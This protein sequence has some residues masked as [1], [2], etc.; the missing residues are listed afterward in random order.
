MTKLVDV[1]KAAGVS[2]G[3]ASN[4]FNRPELVRT[5][6]RARVE[7]VAREL[8]YS[9]PNP[10]GRLLRSGKAHAIGVIPPGAFG[11]SMM[12]HDPWMR[13]F[14]A[15]VSDVCE[16]WGAGL[17]MVSGRDDQKTSGIRNALVDGF[18]LF[19]VDDARRVE[20]AKRRKLPIVIMHSTVGPEVS[21]VN[22]ANRDGMRAAARHLV[23]LG[24]RRFGIMSSLRIAAA[25]VLHPPTGAPHALV[26]AIEGDRDRLAGIEDALAEAGVSINAVPLVEACGSPEEEATFGINPAALLLDSAPDITAVI[27][28]T[29]VM[30]IGVL[31]ETR[32]RG[33]IVPRD[34][35]VVG[36]DDIAAAALTDPPLTTVSQPTQE[37]GRVAGRILLEDGPPRHEMLPTTLVVRGSTAPPR[38]S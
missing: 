7:D 35:S 13:D 25:P 33:M 4:V 37:Q 11:V 28:L 22:V 29:D 27:A 1:A 9:G 18:I 31:D 14:M 15:G 20:E 16:E 34:L 8:G 30:A 21:S 12:F 26:A 19:T 2:Q 5:E 3:T 38:R 32:R 24:H 6:V 10:K 23:A 17:S 36:F